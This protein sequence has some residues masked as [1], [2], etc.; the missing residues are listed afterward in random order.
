MLWF[1][2]TASLEDLLNA[3]YSLYLFEF[4][5]DG[6]YCRITGQ[7]IECSGDLQFDLYLL[8]DV[9]QW[10]HLTFIS[11]HH[12]GTS[13]LRI[14]YA[15]TSVE[16]EADVHQPLDTNSL[17]LGISSDLKLPNGFRGRFREVFLTY[18]AIE[19]SSIPFVINMVKVFDVSTMAYYRF[20]PIKGSFLRDAFRDQTAHIHKTT[21]NTN[22][23]ILS[24]SIGTEVGVNP[25]CDTLQKTDL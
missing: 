11:R 24:P 20:H 9:Q 19:P 12:E 22:T 13:M 14:D 17:F 8:P 25:Y 15:D 6:P 16:V 4:G 3:P 18:G 10:C 23:E 1:K 7:F 21:Y 5:N 2:S